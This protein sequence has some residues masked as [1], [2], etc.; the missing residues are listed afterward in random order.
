M[1]RISS[2]L[3]GQLELL[4]EGGRTKQANTSVR[5]FW[6]P[7]SKN[8]L[9]L[10]FLLSA[11]LPRFE[12]LSLKVLLVNPRPF[13]LTGLLAV[14]RWRSPLWSHQTQTGVSLKLG[15]GLDGGEP[16]FLKVHSQCHNLS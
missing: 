4:E 8:K 2:S 14:E 13:I 9:N 5:K 1:G 3:R 6:D 7:S 11:T 10:L 15:R 12:V 16:R